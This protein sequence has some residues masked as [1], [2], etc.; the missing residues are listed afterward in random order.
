MQISWDQQETFKDMYRRLGGIHT[1]MS[2]VGAIGSLMTESR[3]FAVLSEV[4]RG[5]PNM[6][7]ARG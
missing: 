3:F 6:L 1:L 4:F 5:V 2:F 7:S